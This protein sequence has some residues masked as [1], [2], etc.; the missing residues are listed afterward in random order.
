[1]Y[2]SKDMADNVINEQPANFIDILLNKKFAQQF[3]T[4]AVS[5]AKPTVYKGR[6]IAPT[7]VSN[8]D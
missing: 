3:G 2:L 5:V 6:A 1:M 4:P 7:P 8:T